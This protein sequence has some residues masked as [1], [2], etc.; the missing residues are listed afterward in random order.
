MKEELSGTDFVIFGDHVN[1]LQIFQV[2]IID[3]LQMTLDLSLIKHPQVQNAPPHIGC[4]KVLLNCH[5]LLLK[6]Y[7]GIENMFCLLTWVP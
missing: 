4:L 1:I 7:V 2:D 3:N 5:W 6:P